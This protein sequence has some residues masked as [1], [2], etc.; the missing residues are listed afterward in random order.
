MLTKMLGLTVQE[1]TGKAESQIEVYRAQA[2][3]SLDQRAVRKRGRGSLRR[4]WRAA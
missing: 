2:V 4:C 3:L 1:L